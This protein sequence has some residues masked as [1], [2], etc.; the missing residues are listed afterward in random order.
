MKDLAKLTTRWSL[1]P[2][3]PSSLRPLLLLLLLL[4][5]D[6]REQKV[7]PATAAFPGS[8]QRLLPGQPRV[9]RRLRMLP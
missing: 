9:V 5:P 3:S 1:T 4:S 2:F 6:E 8:Q 7:P